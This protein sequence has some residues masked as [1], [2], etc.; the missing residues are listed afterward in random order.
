LRAKGKPFS[1]PVTG[2]GASRGQALEL[3]RL[4]IAGGAAAVNVGGDGR[5]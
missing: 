2:C 5:L 4:R 3:A 1:V